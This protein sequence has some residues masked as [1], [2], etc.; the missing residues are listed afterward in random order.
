M[1][2]RTALVV[3]VPGAEPVVGHWRHKHDPSAVLGMPAHVTVLWPLGGYVAVRD[4]AAEFCAA[5]RPFDFSLARVATFDRE[6]IWLQPE[7][8]EAFRALLAAAM[9]AFPESPPYEGAI[10]EPTPHLTVGEPADELFDD[11]LAAVRADVAP[12]L[13]IQARAA[14]A[15]LFGETDDGRYVELERLPFSTA[16]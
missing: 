13:P 11:V 9:A 8:D 1:R 5:H 14:T 10:V 15:A 2:N 3:T 16:D 7:P 4:R 6:V 12:R